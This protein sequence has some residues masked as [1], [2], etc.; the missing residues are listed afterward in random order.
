MLV[1]IYPSKISGRQLY[2]YDKLLI[3]LPGF[4]GFFAIIAS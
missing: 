3:E 1:E 4:R 2:E